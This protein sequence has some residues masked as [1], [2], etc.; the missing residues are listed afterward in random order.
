MTLFNKDRFLKVLALAESPNDA[1]TLAAVR[2]A[3]S[4]AREAGLE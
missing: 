2:K 4:M 1:E 3:T